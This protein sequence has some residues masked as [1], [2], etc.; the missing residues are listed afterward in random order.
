MTRVLVFNFFFIKISF[1][2]ALAFFFS[3]GRRPFRFYLSFFSHP[4]PFFLSQRFF[5]FSSLFCFSPVFLSEVFFR[6]KKKMAKEKRIKEKKKKNEGNDGHLSAFS[7]STKENLIYGHHSLH[8]F[9]FFHR[10]HGLKNFFFW[11]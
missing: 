9:F 4:S 5:S 10:P 1:Q 7:N 11:K 6:R 2:G 8:F 3:C